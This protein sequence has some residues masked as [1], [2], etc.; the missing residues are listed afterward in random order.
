MASFCAFCANK[1]RTV[2]I[3]KFSNAL[4]HLRTVASGE[5]D[6]FSFAWQADRSAI[7]LIIKCVFVVAI[8]LSELYSGATTGK[9]L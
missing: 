9:I 3:S 7:R 5:V 8:V 2:S 6:F 1:E 4:T